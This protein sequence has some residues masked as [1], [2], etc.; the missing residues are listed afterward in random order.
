MIIVAVFVSNEEGRVNVK[1][2]TSRS[3][4]VEVVS[5]ANLTTDARTHTVLVVSSVVDHFR[6]FSDTAQGCS[7]WWVKSVDP[8]SDVGIAPPCRI[9]HEHDE[10]K[11]VEQFLHL[12][13]VGSFWPSA[14]R[15]RTW[16]T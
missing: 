3:V 10:Q 14:F 2:F 11:T 1:E 12:V 8:F 9:C 4:V 5:D 7:V 6:W 13:V 16:M 15:R